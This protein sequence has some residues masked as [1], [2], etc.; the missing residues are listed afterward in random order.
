M[1]DPEIV[2]QGLTSVLTLTAVHLNGSK[3]LWGPRL[4]LIANGCWWVLIIQ[5]E[6]WG[7]VPFQAVMFVL[8]VRML[9]LWERDKRRT[10]DASC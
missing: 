10:P 5:G 9:I 4:G 7:L 3:N 2:V 6:L 1:I 8:A